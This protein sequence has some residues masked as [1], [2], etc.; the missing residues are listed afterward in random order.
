VNLDIE[1]SPRPRL[2]VKVGYFLSDTSEAGRANMW[3]LPGSHRSDAIALPEGGRGQPPGGIPILARPGT[4]VLFDRRLWHAATPNWSDVTRKVLFYGYSYRWLRPKDDMA[5]EQLWPAGDAI[6]QQ[7]LGR[8]DTANG[9]YSPSD[10]DV[11]LRA[12]LRE[13]SPEEAP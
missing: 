2:S 8:G 3:V 1:T 13:Y 10:Q 7:L 12:W 6:R 9:H 4:A 11:P 5:V